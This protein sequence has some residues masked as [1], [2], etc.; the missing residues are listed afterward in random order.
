M[1]AGFDRQF[2]FDA[3]LVA[4]FFLAAGV[5]D[6]CLVVTD[7]DNRQFRGYVFSFKS[8]NFGYDFLANLIG[9]GHAFD[10]FGGH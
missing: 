1:E 6:R 9:N 7:Q 10:L 5:Y 4:Y 2:D 3:E 8:F